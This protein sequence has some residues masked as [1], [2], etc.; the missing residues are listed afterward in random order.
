MEENDGEVTQ[1]S[2]PTEES[3]G[4]EKKSRKWLWFIVILVMG[5]GLIYFFTSDDS[6]QSQ[7]ELVPTQLPAQPLPESIV[8]DA[9]APLNCNLSAETLTI[10][11]TVAIYS[12]DAPGAYLSE[13]NL[14]TGTAM[15]F[16]TDSQ[17]TEVTYGPEEVQIV[18]E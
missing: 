2:K 17:S 3:S 13:V 16:T 15:Y 8:V 11:E 12:C 9:G 1:V 10:G 4:E 7:D 18:T 6:K 14:V 5:I